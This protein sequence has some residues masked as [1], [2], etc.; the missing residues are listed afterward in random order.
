[1]TNVSTKIACIFSKGVVPELL[2]RYGYLDAVGCLRGIQDNVRF[3]RIHV[4][5]IL[6]QLE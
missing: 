1:M 4:A 6:F 5:C 2:E 3:L